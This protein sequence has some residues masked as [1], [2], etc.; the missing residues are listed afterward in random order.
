MT[1]RLRTRDFSDLTEVDVA[2]MAGLLEG[3]GSFV[4]RKVGGLPAISIQMTDEDVIARL[5]DM[6]GV[7]YHR[8]TDSRNPDWKPCFSCAIRGSNAVEVM[9]LVVPHMGARRSK[10][11]RSLMDEWEATERTIGSLT[12][13]Q[14][15]EVRARKPEGVKV[16]ASEFGLSKWTIYKI[17]QG[18]LYPGVET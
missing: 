7:K 15:R 10:K 6:W 13:D 12:D 16:L 8:S 18:V 17:W 11:I 5:A 2:W 1:S 3:E 9:K 14:V 4:K